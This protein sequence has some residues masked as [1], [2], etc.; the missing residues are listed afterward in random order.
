MCLAQGHNTVIPV[1]LEPQFKHS[2]TEPLRTQ[3]RV[4]KTIFITSQPKRMLWVL[5]RTL[6][7]RR[8]L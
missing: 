3:E 6:S 2:T 8:L 1:R 5:K 4:T 7:M